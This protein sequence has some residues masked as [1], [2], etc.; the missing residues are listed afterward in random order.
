MSDTEITVVINVHAED[1]K[2]IGR[3]LASVQ[4]QVG[5]P[6]FDILVVADRP[7]KEVLEFLASIES[8]VTV[9][10][11]D[12]GD[13]GLSRNDAVQ[14]AH[15]RYVA[16]LDGDDIFGCF[17]LR[18]AYAKA[19]ELREEL[20]SDSFVLHTEFLLMFGAEQ[21]IH[22]SVG[23]DDPE[24]D[25]KDILQWNQ[26]SALAFAPKSVFEAHPYRKIGDGHG[27]EDQMFHVETLHAG[28]KHRIVPGSMHA[29][30]IKRDATSL[31]ARTAALNAICPRMPYFDRDDIPDAQKEVSKEVSVPASVHQQALFIHHQIGE[32]E[33]VMESQMRMRR[34]PH[35]RIWKDQRALRV[36]IGDAKHVVLVRDLNQGGA[37]KY[38]I[39]WAAA[40][41]AE[42]ERVVIIETERRAKSAW[43]SR[44]I[45]RGVKVVQWELQVTDL[46]V[47]EAL[48]AMQRA[49]VQA[50]L[51]SVFVC[52]SPIGWKLIHETA[53]QVLARKVF[54]ASFAPI[55]FADGFTSCP[56][57]FLRNTPPNLTII[58]DN[59]MHS[60]RLI[61]AQCA[62]VIIVRPRATYKGTTKRSQLKK[63]RFRVLWAGR[64]TPE[65]RP[66]VLPSLAAALEG[67]ADIHV[68]GPVVPMRGPENLKYRGPFDGFESIDGSYDV[69]LMT[70]AFEGCPNTAMEAVLAGLPVVGPSVG[71]LPAFA[72]SVYDRFDPIEVAQRILSVCED[73]PS[74]EEARKLVNFWA[75]SFD[76]AVCA[77]AKR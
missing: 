32:R 19:R 66:D 60:D 34:L 25:G 55:P 39:D 11:C 27:F 41:A 65:K 61:D 43:V 59:E 35:E 70:S 4:T 48:D 63:D 22:K 47:K 56:A 52:N 73:A 36:A 53:S 28:V 57:Y 74:G 12:N 51:D 20:K 64:G 72:A 8:S 76:G 67:K 38:A 62:E 16:F 6:R 42:G 24:Y 75:E 68:W 45:E 7:S 50:D 26:W 5:A 13:L 23:D 69:Y 21:F 9:V 33:L 29:I 46:N 18:D 10:Q 58:T 15:G 14:L 2:W 31:A 44:A 37:E 30:R 54:V 49:L 3:A 40:L 1:P 71:A 17:W 77:L